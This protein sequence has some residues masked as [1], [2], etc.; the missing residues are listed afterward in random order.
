VTP[1]V[2]DTLDRHRATASFFC[3]GERAA[4]HP[5]LVREI[6]ARGHSVESHSHRHSLAFAWYGPRRLRREIASAQRAISDAAGVPPVFFRAPYG[7]RNPILDFELA[8]LGLT[9]VTWKRRGYDA[10]D[11]DAPRVL[12][13][14]VKRLTAGDV[15]MLHDGNTLRG[16][17]SQAT[18][19]RVLPL[20]LE[21]LQSVR[22]RP[23]SLR[24]A[25]GVAKPD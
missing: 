17:R 7:T 9:Y 24:M 18:V 22:L 19:L 25:F 20:L 13:R 12:H 15:L 16:D 21:H 14:L 10:V 2:L 1:R 6:V 8:R 4:A 11:T 3:I 5:S 23:V